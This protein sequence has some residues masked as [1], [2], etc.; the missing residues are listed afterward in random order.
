MFLVINVG[1]NILPIFCSTMLKKI[2]PRFLAISQQHSRL[3]TWFLCQND[4]LNVANTATP[5]LA[6]NDDNHVS[7]C[8]YFASIV[9]Y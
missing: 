9:L 1:Q 7:G 6:C 3:K 2:H 8:L 5:T 4:Q